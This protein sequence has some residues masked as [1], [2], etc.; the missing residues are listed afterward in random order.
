MGRAGIRRKDPRRRL[1]PRRYRRRGVRALRL[2]P[3]LRV[4]TADLAFL[5]AAA[6]GARPPTL[7]PHAPLHPLGDHL[8]PP[9][10]DVSGGGAQHL[11]LPP[12]LR[13]GEVWEG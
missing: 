11:P 5:P 7:A 13:A 8:C 10:R 1:S 3:L 12:F 2:L 4:G 9:V 6:G